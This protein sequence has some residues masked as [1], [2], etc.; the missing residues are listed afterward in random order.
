MIQ[1]LIKNWWL[2]GLRGLL[3]LLFS[4]MTF[5]MR[6]S[7]ETLTLRE[8][9]LKGM[10]VFLGIL[11]LTAGVCTVAAGLWRAASGKWWLLVV[12]GVAVS[13][14]GVAAILAS[15]FTFDTLMYIVVLLAAAI[16]FVELAT[17]RTLRRHMPDEWL[18]GLAGAVSVGFAL[19]FFLIKPQ[20]AGPMFI[21]LGFY[22]GFSAACMLAL[23][24]RLRSLRAS[25]H[26]LA[27]SVSR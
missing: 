9:A 13:A 22:S 3:A 18:L 14:A 25:I 26:K 23:A 4:V 11:A 27:H 17:A 10:V 21:W 24:F 7:A 8:F 19:A 1:T 2:L 16:G 20:E 6:S 12:D 15:S 5:L